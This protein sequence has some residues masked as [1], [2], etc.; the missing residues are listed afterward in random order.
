MAVPFTVEQVRTLYDTETKDIPYYNAIMEHLFHRSTMGDSNHLLTTL[1]QGNI[2]D[3]IIDPRT[4][5]MEI[6]MPPPAVQALSSNTT[7]T[8]VHHSEHTPI[9]TCG[10][11]PQ[12]TPYRSRGE[13]T[14]GILTNTTNTLT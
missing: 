5:H 13:P 9:L 10:H 12:R 7:L 1:M 3:P 14:I 2:L 8:R 11:S 4:I 6:T